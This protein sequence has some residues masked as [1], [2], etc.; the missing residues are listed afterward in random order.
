MKPFAAFCLT[1]LLAA[2]S[3]IGESRLSNASAAHWLVWYE[4]TGNKM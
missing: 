1:G 2:F 4:E 3:P